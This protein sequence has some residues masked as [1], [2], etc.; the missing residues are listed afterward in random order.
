MWRT[1]ACPNISAVLS[2]SKSEKWHWIS[3]DKKVHIH[4]YVFD[5]AKVKNTIKGKSLEPN[6][7]KCKSFKGAVESKIK[8]CQIFIWIYQWI[9]A[10]LLL[11]ITHK[12]ETNR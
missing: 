10:L 7:A 3:A 12:Q 4:I 8:S 6:K 9:T 5:S 1:V 11:I 2:T